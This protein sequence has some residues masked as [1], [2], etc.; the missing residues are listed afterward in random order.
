MICLDKKKNVAPT[1]RGGSVDFFLQL[2]AK[3]NDLIRQEEKMWHQRSHLH[4]MI[5]RDKN[6]GYFHNRASQKFQR[7]NISKLWGPNGELH[8]RDDKIASLLVD[9]Y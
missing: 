6:T 7:N 5:C 1:L 2:K 9:Y 4:W 8:S 3:V